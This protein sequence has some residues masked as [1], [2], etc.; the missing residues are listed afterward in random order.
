MAA[1]VT[2][3]SFWDNYDGQPPLNAKGNELGI[4]YSIGWTF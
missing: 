4:S 2:D 1:Q 3:F